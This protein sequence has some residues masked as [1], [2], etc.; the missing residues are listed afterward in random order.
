M[1]NIKIDFEESEKSIPALIEEQIPD[2]ASVIT[3]KFSRDISDNMGEWNG[4]R[5]VADRYLKDCGVKV[6]ASSAGIHLNG[7]SQKFHIHY[8]LITE[9]HNEPS[10]PS[11]HRKRW[12]A[13]NEEIMDDISFKYQ[14]LKK[15]QEK[16][17]VLS[18]PLKEGRFT[19]FKNESYTYLGK[20]MTKEMQKFL[21][22]AGKAIYDKELG[23]AMRQEKCEERK[24]ATLTNLY[25]LC[26][27]NKAQF[28]SFREMMEWLDINYIAK[29][30]LTEMPCPKNYKT[31]CQ[32][33]AVYLGFLKYSQL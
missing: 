20:P 21:V 10:N 19:T 30:E 7:R 11:Q 24:Q 27:Q 26:N 1:D 17:A 4:Y 3:I 29:L 5:A 2:D 25:D 8:H 31:N 33:I 9:R 28:S 6:L 12:C 18:Y 32:K 16:Y 23:L 22:D 13:K 15:D 14:L